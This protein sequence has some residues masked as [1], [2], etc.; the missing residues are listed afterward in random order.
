MAF[1]RNSRR[2]GSTRFN[3]VRSSTRNRGRFTKRSGARKTSGR[4]ASNVQTIR[5]VV[6]QPQAAAVDTGNP[7]GPVSSAVK[8]ARF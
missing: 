1:K 3:R 5:I 4:R 2:S 7:F 8:K 6:E